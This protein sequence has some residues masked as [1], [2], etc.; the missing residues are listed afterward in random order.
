MPHPVDW[1]QIGDEP[2][3]KPMTNRTSDAISPHDAT[4][5]WFQLHINTNPLWWP[6][7]K[8]WDI[9]PEILWAWRPFFIAWDYFLNDMY[10]C[11]T[12][13]WKFGNI[14]IVPQLPRVLGFWGIVLCV[15]PTHVG[16]HPRPP[17]QWINLHMKTTEQ[18]IGIIENKSSIPMADVY[19][20]N[21]VV[22]HY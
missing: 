3:T 13:N 1:R 2:S 9:L 7:R 4:V 5:S 11:G 22:L 10:C 19:G 15:F 16:Q 18:R 12:D 6:T 14:H 21:T 20:P 8:G 17:T